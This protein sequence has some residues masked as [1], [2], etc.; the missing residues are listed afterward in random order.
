LIPVKV[1]RDTGVQA[2][3]LSGLADSD[4][5]VL[6]PSGDLVSGTPV[7]AVVVKPKSPRAKPEM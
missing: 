1:G 3:I 2:E 7:E 6:H 5:V 4:L